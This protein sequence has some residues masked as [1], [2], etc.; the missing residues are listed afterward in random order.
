MGNKLGTPASSYVGLSL[1]FD[2]LKSGDLVF[3]GN[4][5]KDRAK[6]PI[7]E[8]VGVVFR[9]PTLYAEHAETLLLEYSDGYMQTLDDYSC[10]H[11]AVAGVRL[12]NFETRVKSASHQVIDVLHCNDALALS[13]IDTFAVVADLLKRPGDDLGQLDL[14]QLDLGLHQALPQRDEAMTMEFMLAKV[15]TSL[16]LCDS[17]P[18]KRFTA[19]N[20]YRK[21]NDIARV[22]YHYQAPLRLK[23]ARVVQK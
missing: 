19:P 11:R 12:V 8:H 13:E 16:Q 18:V 23:D 2:L 5:Q 15:M 21:I 17:L 6:T 14:G 7:W 3:F 9:F 1:R 10:M 22:N 20:L 4:A